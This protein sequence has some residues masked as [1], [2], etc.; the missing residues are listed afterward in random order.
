ME[1]RNIRSVLKI[2]S[3]EWDACN[4][5]DEWDALCLNSSFPFLRQ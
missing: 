1:K 2:L 4:L 3:D 5:S